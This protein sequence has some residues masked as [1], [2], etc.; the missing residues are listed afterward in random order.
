MSNNQNEKINTAP[1]T[2]WEAIDALEREEL[3]I[4]KRKKGGMKLKLFAISLYKLF[5]VSFGFIRAHWHLGYS[6][7]FKYEN[8]FGRGYGGVSCG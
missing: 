7:V 1:L 8:I 2:D 3:K 6:A 5:T 4:P